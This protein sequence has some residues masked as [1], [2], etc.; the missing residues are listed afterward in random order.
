MYSYD[1]LFYGFCFGAFS[2]SRLIT[3]PIYGFLSDRYS[4]KPL[5]ICALIIS[6]SGNLVYA[7]ARS[8][9][10]IIAGRLMDG[11]GAGTCHRSVCLTPPPRC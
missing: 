11:V 1:S 9:W 7:L 6:A 5:V 10:M 3:A 2:F 4:V 8:K